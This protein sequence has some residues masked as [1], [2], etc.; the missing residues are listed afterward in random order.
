MAL[1]GTLDFSLITPRLDNSAPDDDLDDTDAIDI[2][3]QYGQDIAELSESAEYL[4]QRESELK[5]SVDDEKAPAVDK[6]PDPEK[7]KN[8]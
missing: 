4:H 2:I 6:S 3:P 7:P 5:K 1:N 8:E